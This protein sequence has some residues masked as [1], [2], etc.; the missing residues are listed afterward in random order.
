MDRTTIRRI[1]LLVIVAV[2]FFTAS[3]FTT[4]AAP[5]WTNSA[6]E[7]VSKALQKIGVEDGTITGFYM[8]ALGEIADCL[9][10]MDEAMTTATGSEHNLADLFDTA[11]TDTLTDFADVTSDDEALDKLDDMINEIE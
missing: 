9:N 3:V 5:R 4:L 8:Y 2:T 1:A 6:E 7:T 10:I 11:I